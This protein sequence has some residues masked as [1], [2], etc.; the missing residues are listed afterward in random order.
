M[1]LVLDFLNEWAINHVNYQSGN[2]QEVAKLKNGIE[3]N[4]GEVGYYDSYAMGL[5]IEVYD[6]L[7]NEIRTSSISI[8]DRIVTI[9]F[10]ENLRSKTL[11]NYYVSYWYQ[12][13]KTKNT[14]RF[15]VDYSEGILYTSE[16]IQNIQN[17]GAIRIYQ[18]RL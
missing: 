7:G 12:N 15:S 4:F 10:S 13:K 11:N 2:L 16:D 1:Y 5:D 6:I 18:M 14:K 3:A 17:K 9:V 8:E